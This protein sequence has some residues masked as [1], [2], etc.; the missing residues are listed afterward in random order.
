MKM[1]LMNHQAVALRIK[2]LRSNGPLVKLI[3]TLES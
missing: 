2:I 1:I 3:Y